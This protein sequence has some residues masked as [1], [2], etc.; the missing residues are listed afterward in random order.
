M[1]W[2]TSTAR[3]WQTAGWTDFQRTPLEPDLYDKYEISNSKESDM[4]YEPSLCEINHNIGLLVHFY[5]KLKDFY[6]LLKSIYYVLPRRFLILVMWIF[7]IV[8]RNG[9]YSL[10]FILL[11]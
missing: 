9:Q 2:W 5:I 1:A 3:G 4:H 8:P 10:L 7:N 11:R 6:L